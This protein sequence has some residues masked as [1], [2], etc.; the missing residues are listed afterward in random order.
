MELKPTPTSP[1]VKAQ[2]TQELEA[3]YSD[4]SLQELHRPPGRN[5]GAFVIILAIVVGVFSGFFGSWFFTTMFETDP[6]LQGSVTVRLG[7]TS[8]GELFDETELARLQRS[9]LGIFF[10]KDTS[11][12]TDP[13]STV[14]GDAD[15]LATAT[16]LTSDGWL[17]TPK[18][19]MSDLRREY[20]AVSSD[21]KVYPVSK[22]LG[23][24]ATPLYYIKIEAS[25]LPTLEFISDE[26]AAQ[27]D[28]VFVI[29]HQSDRG[30]Q[31]TDQVITDRTAFP[32]STGADLIV[33][34]DAVASR[35][36][37]ARPLSVFEQGALVV[38]ADGKIVGVVES[39]QW[40]SN[41]AVAASAIH[42]GLSSLLKNGEIV[43]PVLGVHYLDLSALP[44]LSS[45]FSQGRSAGAYVYGDREAEQPAVQP[46]SP[47]EKADVRK[48][49]IILR[50]DKTSVDQSLT[51]SD[52]VLRY[53]SGETVTLLIARD[54]QEEEIDLTLSSQK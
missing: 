50:I 15:Q 6:T 30:S 23:D 22:I 11:S 37:L 2:K 12:V 25:Q 53:Q 17:V 7:N 18:W 54:G 35:L 28:E 13:L 26:A 24:P 40:P 47:A 48:G 49:D 20:V 5:G 46:G 36:A 9:V 31:I 42:T 33:S 3:L 14:Y 1:K 16:A 38:A 45:V 19:G 32:A 41:Q 21:G 27:T 29:S 8:T 51:L 39:D 44:S 10:K 4:K 34:S 43:R 52:I